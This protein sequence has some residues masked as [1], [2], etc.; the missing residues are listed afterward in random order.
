M[1]GEAE[2]VGLITEEDIEE[3]ITRSRREEATE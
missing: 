3:W 2:K 1:K